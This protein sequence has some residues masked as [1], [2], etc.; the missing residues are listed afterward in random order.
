MQ[1]QLP[2]RI[3]PAVQGSA[4]GAGERVVVSQELQREVRSRRGEG[5]GPGGV[6]TPAGHSGHPP[7]AQLPQGLRGRL[8]ALPG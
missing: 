2:L 3:W 5:G 1:S 6:C 4:R 7:L 8:A